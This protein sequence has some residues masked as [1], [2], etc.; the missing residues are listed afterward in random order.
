MIASTVTAILSGGWKMGGF[1][2][3]VELH[4]AWSAAN[5]ASPTSLFTT[6]GFLERLHKQLITSSLLLSRPKAKPGSALQTH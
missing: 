6:T 2:L 1:F 5:W 4:R 3:V